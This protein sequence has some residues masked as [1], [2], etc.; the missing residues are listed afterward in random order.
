MRGLQRLRDLPRDRQ[1]FVRRDVPSLEPLLKRRTFHQFHDEELPPA[2]F[3]QTMNGGDVRVI[4]RGK[5]ACLTLESGGAIR[6]GRED[7]WQD[8]DGHA[9]TKLRVGRAVNFAHATGPDGGLNFVL[10]E[11]CSSA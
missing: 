3:L 2:D 8:F 10:P 6:I 1:R 9:P 7:F 11:S 5:R 4:Q